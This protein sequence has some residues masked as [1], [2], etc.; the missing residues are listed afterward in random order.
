MPCREVSTMA[1]ADTDVTACLTVRLS[2][3]AANDNRRPALDQSKEAGP[4]SQI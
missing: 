4:F 1:F 3:K 2:L